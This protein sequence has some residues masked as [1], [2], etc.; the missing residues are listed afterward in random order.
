MIKVSLSLL[1]ILFLGLFFLLLSLFLYL[2]IQKKIRNETRKKID[3]YKET[4]RLDMFHFLQSGNEGPLNPNGSQEKFMAL[5]ELL[6]EYSDVLDSE[7]IKQRISDFAKRHLTK[8]IVEKLKKK[9]WSLRMNA[10]YSIE[11]FYMDHLIDLLH[12]LYRKKNTTVPEKI[13]ILRLFAKFNDQ[14]I[15]GYL[16]ELDTT[17]SDFAL[18]SILSL[19]EE[20]SF[21]KLVNDFDT[22]SKQTQYMIIETIGKEQYLHHH[23]LLGKLLQRDDEELKIRTLKAYAYTGAPINETMLS[24]FFLSSSWQVRMMAAKVAGVRRL[25]VFEAQL[26]T[27]LSD[28]EYVVRAE[29]AKAI[30]QFKGGINRLKRVIEETKDEFARDMAKEWIS[31]ESGDD[32]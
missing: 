12:D 28:Q 20:D 13:Q 21:N 27:L 17:I 31:K 16:K 30:L 10:L 14:R 11:D 23:I 32:N 29:A 6:N 3:A 22:L 7:D 2:V 15:V 1:F 18:L 26:I 24:A 8:Y 25:S 9:R 4:Y 19:L 5:I